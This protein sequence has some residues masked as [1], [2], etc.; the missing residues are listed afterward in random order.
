[1]Q[2]R[3]FPRADKNIVAI[4]TVLAHRDAAVRRNGRTLFA[5]GINLH[6]REWRAISMNRRKIAI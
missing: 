1:M 6:I 2:N 5:F 3:N 4:Q